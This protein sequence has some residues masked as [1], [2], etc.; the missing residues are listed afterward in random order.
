LL[1]K[2]AHALAAQQERDAAHPSR[3]S[4][5]SAWFSEKYT[6]IDWPSKP[7]MSIVARQ[8]VPRKSRLRTVPRS[9]FGRPSSGPE[10]SSTRSSGRRYSRTGWPGAAPL[11]VAVS[12]TAPTR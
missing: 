5:S 8:K 11:A 6:S 2:H 1:G 7:S 4:S 12:S 9:R 10:S 3:T